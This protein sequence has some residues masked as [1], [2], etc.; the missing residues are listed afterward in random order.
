MKKSTIIY[1]ACAVSYL[2]ISF[3]AG[4]AFVKLSAMTAAALF[5]LTAGI[6]AC[7][8]RKEDKDE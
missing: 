3:L 5:A 7:K 4:H 2:A 6:E 8:S 1:S